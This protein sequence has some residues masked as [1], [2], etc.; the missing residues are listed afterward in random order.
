[1]NTAKPNK[2]RKLNYQAKKRVYHCLEK[3]IEKRHIFKIH[4][5]FLILNSNIVSHARRI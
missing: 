2:K 4:K 1:M 5:A 3:D